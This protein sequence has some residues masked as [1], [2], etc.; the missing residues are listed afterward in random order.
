MFVTV[1]VQLYEFVIDCVC[2]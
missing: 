2:V 1:T